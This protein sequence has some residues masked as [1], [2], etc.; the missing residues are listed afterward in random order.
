MTTDELYSLLR[1]KYPSDQYALLAEVRDASGFS[2]RRSADAIAIGLWP[3]RGNLIEGFEM[4]VS[5][6]D[7]IRELKTPEKA[8]AFV[9]Y[10]DSWYVLAGSKDI[11]RREE[12][13]PNWGL[14]VASGRG[15][16]CEVMAKPL[17]PVP[18][19]RTFLAAMLKRACAVALDDPQ[20]VKLIAEK[21]AEARK[22]EGTSQR[23]K[24]ESLQAKVAELQ[25]RINTFQEASGVEIDGWRGGDI[26]K[27]VRV[28]LDGKYELGR[29]VDM[30]RQIGNLHQWFQ[31]NVPEE[32]A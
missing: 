15:L 26:G 16:A 13:P 28:I 9:K 5:R 14:M 32:S 27:A 30:R 25:A 18:L 8:E 21:S 7:W 24:I 22:N 31:E 12:L 4:K 23:Y 19:P 11:V 29:L 2:A 20:V 10:C 3:S 6:A 17:S 1:V